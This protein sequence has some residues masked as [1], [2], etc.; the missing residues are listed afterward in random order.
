MLAGLEAGS[1][2]LLAGTVGGGELE[3]QLLAEAGRLLADQPDSFSRTQRSYPLGPALGQCCGGSV[4]AVLEIW[5]ASQLPALQALLADRPAFLAHGAKDNSLPAA[6]RRDAPRPPVASQPFIRRVPFYLYG[7]G[8]VGR[9]VMAITGDLP[10]DRYWVDTEQSRFPA[11]MDTSITRVIA[12]DPAHIARYAESQAIHLVMSYS[13]ALDQAI[14][15]T[16]L[17]QDDFF[18]LGLIGSATKRARFESRL[19]AAGI[20]KTAGPA[21]LSY[22][23]GG[24]TGQGPGLFGLVCCRAD[25]RLAGGAGGG[26]G[27]F[28]FSALAG[29]KAERSL[30]VAFQQGWQIKAGQLAIFYHQ[31]A[32]DDRM[33]G[34]NRPA[35]DERCHRVCPGAGEINHIAVINRHIRRIARTDL[36]DISAVQHLSPAPRC[37]PQGF[38]RIQGSRVTTDPLQQQGL[39][40]LCQHMAGI[41]RRRPIHPQPDRNPNIQHLAQRGNAAG[42]PHIGTG[43]MGNP[44]AGAGKQLLLS[45]VQ[46]HTMGVPDI[47]SDPADRLRIFARPHPEMGQRIVYILIIFSQMRM[48]P[49]PQLAGH[50]GCFAHQPDRDRKRRAGGEGYLRHRAF[51]GS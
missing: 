27:P 39:A 32:M 7:A 2:A 46:L 37:Q 10:L 19:A 25:C 29:Q 33:P 35:K 15:H 47:L 51:F 42:Q 21:G 11:D 48:Q 24:Y 40:R 12:S 45:G 23:V 50:L 13:H 41:I 18:Q 30:F 34:F 49:H 44:G 43:A 8:H 28:S 16:V 38:A 14:C 4:E 26:L 5:P 36:A 1:G 20:S 22:R 17:K 31:P 6:H 3:Y 9:A